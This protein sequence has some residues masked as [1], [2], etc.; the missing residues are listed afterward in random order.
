MSVISDKAADAIR[1]PSMISRTQSVV[2]AAILF[3]A[4]LQENAYF[5]NSDQF[6]TNVADIPEGISLAR[7]LRQVCQS[8]ADRADRLVLERIE[9]LSE[10]S[11]L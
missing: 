2:Q 5:E 11:D 6:D 4:W 7:Q 10:H 9:S 1:L 3:G 8:L